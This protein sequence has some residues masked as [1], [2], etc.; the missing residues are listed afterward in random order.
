MALVSLMA[1][2]MMP[3][4]FGSFEAR[5]GLLGLAAVEKSNMWRYL[6]FAMGG[7]TACCSSFRSHI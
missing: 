2:V 1:V 3:F 4:V 5:D 6:G 7:V